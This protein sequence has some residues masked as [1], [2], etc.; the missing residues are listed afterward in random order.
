MIQHTKDFIQR[1]AS[2]ASRDMQSFGILASVTIAQAILESG[3]GASELATHANALFGIKADKRWSGRTYEI[4]TK[5]W[6]DG[7][8]PVII[9]DTFRAYSTW[10]ESIA[11]HTVFLTASPRYRYVIGEQDY[12]KAC[13]ALQ[14]AG[15]STDPDYANKLIRLIEKYNLTEYDKRENKMKKP[16]N[17]ANYTQKDRNETKYIVVH[18]TS[19]KGD[20]AKNN[21]DYFAREKVGASAHFFVDEKEIWESV[22]ETS[23]AWHCG[24]KQYKHS[25]CRN[26]NSIG[27]EICMNDRAGKVRQGSIDHAAKLVR[28]LMQRYKIPPEYVLRHYDVTGK[29]CPRPMVDNP[30]L[31]QAFKNKLIAEQEESMKI[32]KH[33]T[34]MPEWAQGTF[35]RLIDAGIVKVDEKGEIAVQ[36]SSVQPMVYLDRLCGGKIEELSAIMKAR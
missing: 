4:K 25:E 15:Y 33:T 9:V 11:D 8:E 6:Y 16:C 29:C 22:P 3:W 21:A 31:W 20:T 32:Y 27:V 19:N 24:A 1:I 28:E 35:R 26:A 5:E 7:N 34:E 10:K 18:Y 30:A 17:P 14:A 12:K 23:V 36:E 2:A 13:K